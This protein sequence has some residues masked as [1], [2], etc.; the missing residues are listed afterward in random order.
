[1]V[2]EV[3]TLLDIEMME[4]AV[5][6][7]NPLLCRSPH[8]LPPAESKLINVV[9]SSVCAFRG[10]NPQRTL[11]NKSMGLF[12]IKKDLLPQTAITDSTVTLLLID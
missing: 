2:H 6:G 12:K 9:C 3:V 11:H 7:P 10:F 4:E 1:M 8:Y 5:S